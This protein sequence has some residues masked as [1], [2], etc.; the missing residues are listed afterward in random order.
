MKS[1]LQFSPKRGAKQDN[2]DLDFDLD[3]KLIEALKK[4]KKD[5]KE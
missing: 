4:H 2:Q 5:T 1:A 3:S